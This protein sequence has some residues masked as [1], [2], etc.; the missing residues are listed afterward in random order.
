MAHSF[1]LAEGHFARLQPVLPQKVRGVPR[2]DAAKTS[3]IQ[4]IPRRL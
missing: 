3:L 2:Q 1:W 4:P